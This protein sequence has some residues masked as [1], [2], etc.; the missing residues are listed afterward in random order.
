[1]GLQWK[2]PQTTAREALPA[3]TGSADTEGPP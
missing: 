2:R 1:M 3:V